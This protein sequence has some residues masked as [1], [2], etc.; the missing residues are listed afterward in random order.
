VFLDD[1]DF[2]RG[3][4]SA[5]LPEVAVVPGFKDP[6]F[7]TAEV[8]RPGWFDVLALTDTDRKRPDLYRTRALRSDFS[9]GFSSTGDYLHALELSVEM[10]PANEFTVRRVAQLAARTNQFNLTGIRFDEATT[11]QMSSSADHLVASVAV[12]DRFGDE[13]LVGAFWVERG[14]SVWRVLNMVLSCRVFNRGIETAAM[15]WLAGRAVA[16]GASAIEGRFVPS[17]KNGVASGFWTETGFSPVDSGGSDGSGGSVYRYDLGGP[18]L[19]TPE[20]ITLR[21]RE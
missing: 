1:S 8:L 17:A 13:G 2:E 12:S 7:I 15:S 20:W 3:Y 11:A 18:E 9:S 10:A 4:V 14:S 16:A 6:S 21:E 5:E 19:S